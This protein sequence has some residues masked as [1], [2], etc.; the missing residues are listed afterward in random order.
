MIMII[1]IVSV[2]VVIWGLWISFVMTD[3]KHDA[4]EM[5]IHVREIETGVDYIINKLLKRNKQ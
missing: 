1:I 5:L 2:L 4:H 3:I